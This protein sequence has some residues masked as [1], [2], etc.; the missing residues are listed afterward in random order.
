M[1]K[2]Q[3]AVK[4]LGGHVWLHDGR[5][6]VDG[7]EDLDAVIAR[8]TKVFGVHS[9]CPAVEMEKED[10]EAVAAQAVELMRGLK[11]TFKVD[12]R[13]SDKLYPMDSPAINSELGYRI[14]QAV[15]ELKVDIHHPDHV[16]NV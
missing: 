11:G 9:V 8:V 1:K 15:P 2:V 16:L 12:A 10:F 6:F 7:F 13:R 14:L 4:E 3:H 5:V